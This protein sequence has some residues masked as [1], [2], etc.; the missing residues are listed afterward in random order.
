MLLHPRA[1]YRL[2]RSQ[3]MVNNN[4]KAILAT[5][6]LGK[7][8][9]EGLMLPDESYRMGVSQIPKI[10]PNLVTQN[11]ATREVKTA[12]GG[13][14]QLLKVSSEL[15]PKK[16]NTI[17]LDQ[18]V[19]IIQWAAFEKGDKEA[20]ALAKALMQETLERRFDKAFNKKVS[21]EEYNNRLELRRE[22][23]EAR[24]VLTRAIKWYQDNF[25]QN[26][27]D[28]E[29][30]FLYIHVSNKINKGLFDKTSKK[31]KEHFKFGEHDLIR[32]YL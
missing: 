12:L 5:V 31:I 26:L 30:K 16:V 20:R 9:L 7:T 4:R 32:D 18:V 25:G 15:N 1:E 24:H 2:N 29:S 11:N 17:S 23:I 6:Q 14:S 3:H 19:E 22:N 10:L 21:E 8:E 13:N 28:N 27:S